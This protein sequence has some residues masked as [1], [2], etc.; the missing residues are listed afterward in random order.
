MKSNLFV[1]LVT[2]LLSSTILLLLNGCSGHDPDL[3]GKWEATGLEISKWD[4]G[5]VPPGLERRF[6]LYEDGTGSFTRGERTKK[7]YWSTINEGLT[8]KYHNGGK[9]TFQYSVEGNELWVVQM[10]D[11]KFFYTRR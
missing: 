4:I 8:F 7:L 5:D 9:E 11:Q 2:I 6:E 3:V 1:T 10:N